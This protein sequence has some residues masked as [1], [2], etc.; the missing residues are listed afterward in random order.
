[1]L[2]VI[3]LIIL[4]LLLFQCG[5]KR[6]QPIPFPQPTP[7]PT[8][9]PTPEPSPAASPIALATPHPTPSIDV[10]KYIHAKPAGATATASLADGLLSAVVQKAQD[11]PAVVAVHIVGGG[12]F[13]EPVV[14]RKY[15]TFDSGTYSCDATSASVPAFLARLPKVEADRFK[16]SPVTDYG[17]FTIADGVYVGGTWRLPQAITDQINAKGDPI[18]RAK[19]AALVAAGEGT[20]I[21]EPTFSLDLARPS[22]EVFQALGDVGNSHTGKAKNITIQGFTIKGRQKVYDGGVRS[23]VLL[24]NCEH[25]AAIDVYLEDTASIGITAGGS[26]L[27]NDNF[28][29]DILFTR[30]MFSGVAGA[31]IATINTENAFTFENY[32]KRPGHHDPVFGGGVCGYDHETNSPAD[33]TK[34]IWVYNNLIDYEDAHIEGAGSAICLQ[35]PY[36][37]KKLGENNAFVVNNTI[38]GGRDTNVRHFMSNGIYLVGLRKFT[39]S[40]NY[41]FRT[42]QNAFQIYNVDIGVISDNI[43]DS[44]GHGGNPSFWSNGMRNT[45]VT[46]NPF[47]KRDLPTNMEAGFFE[48]CG[49]GNTYKDNP[50]PGEDPNAPP[51]RVCP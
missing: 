12:S 37:G 2:K 8:I 46:R 31:N 35:D 40:A 11:D 39:V 24:G 36:I 48:K 50:I 6:P 5:R 23:T 19:K 42:G 29:N 43:M 17:C 21:L 47:I 28:A 51:R 1:M 3:P 4:S 41:I 26:G 15:T 25:C 14:L 32:V 10:S 49:E 45:M 13:I 27:Q 22:V 34:N 44:T 16:L 38:V 33:H 7:V 30:N 20:T 9:A 18:E